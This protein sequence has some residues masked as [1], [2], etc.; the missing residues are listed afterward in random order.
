[1]VCDSDLYFLHPNH[2]K[3]IKHLAL[4]CMLLYQTLGKKILF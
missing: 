2:K 4:D 1:M 3:N